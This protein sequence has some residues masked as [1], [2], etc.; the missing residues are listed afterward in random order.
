MKKPPP[1]HMLR[2]GG[3]YNTVRTVL[4][5]SVGAAGKQTGLSAE[6]CCISGQLLLLNQ[7]IVQQR[8]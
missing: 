2:L 6:I 1:G 5:E 3:F 7:S 4:A 8:I